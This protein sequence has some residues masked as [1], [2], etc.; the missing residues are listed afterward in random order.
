MKNI[1]NKILEIAVE[2]DKL[3][4][5]SSTDK[6]ETKNSSWDT[7]AKLDV[8]SDILIEKK[9][10]ELCLSSLWKGIIGDFWWVKQIVSEEK[11]GIIEVNNTW[12]YL[13][14]YDPLDWSSLIDVNLSIWTIFWIYKQDFNWKNLVAS[15]YIVY[16]P[17]V[18]VV[19]ADENWVKF[20]R[21]SPLLNKEG[22]GV[23][24]E[25]KLDKLNN[26]GKILS[27]WGA[28]N[29]WLEYHRNII[30]NFWNEWYRLRYSGWMVPDL[31]QIILKW[32]GLFTYPEIKVKNSLLTEEFSPLQNWKLRKLFEV[33]PFAFIFEKLWWAAIDKNWTRIL[34]LWYSDLHESTSCYFWSEFEIELCRDVLVK[35]N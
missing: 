19:F 26:K 18:E 35:Q 12:E 10:K 4:K 21:L 31:H 5:T 2:I 23:V 27:P 32:W 17:R 22:L 30:N 34:D 28:N 33:F 7:Q 16:W 14:A 3:I 9:L 6:I 15:A 1:K 13:I 29:L 25:K 11:A 8:L 20:Y 24:K